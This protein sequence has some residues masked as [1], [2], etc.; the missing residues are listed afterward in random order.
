VY[1]PKKLKNRLRLKEPLNIHTT[2]GVGGDAEVWAEPQDANELALLLEHCK[3]IKAP[4][5]VIGRGSNLLFSENGFKG[6]VFSLASGYFSKCKVNNDKII[7]G[8]GVALQKLLQVACKEGLSGLEFLA[9]IPASVGGA[10]VM[11]AGSRKKGIGDLVDSIT[12]MNKKG[13]VEKI[14]KDRLLFSYRKSN[15]K[16]YL[17]LDVELKLR[18]STPKAVKK[19]MDL[20]VQNKQLTQDTKSKSAGCIFKNPPHVLSAAEMIEACGL[21]NTTHGGAQIS[22]KHAN[23]II[24]R[25]QAT[26]S[27]VLYLIKMAKTEVK[28][29]FGV[30][31]SPEVKIIK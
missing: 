26:A 8:A 23:Y 22:D 25:N 20:Y 27:D 30:S 29:K 3:L 12:V 21:K 15:L 2:I 17:I 13:K 16:K 18:K 24:N 14:K 10:V 5:I 19:N 1:W 6:V 11:N 7:C 31:L 4:Y 9:G 28:K